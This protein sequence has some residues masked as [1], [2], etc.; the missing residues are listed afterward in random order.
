MLETTQLS[1]KQIGKKIG[2]DSKTIEKLIKPDAEHTFKI[3]LTSGKSFPAYRIQHNNKLGPYKGGIR[4]HPGVDKDEVQA[5][6]T[7]MSFKT[8]AVGLPLGGGKGGITVDPNQLDDI[9][10]EELSRKYAQYLTPHI[11]PN[12]DVPAP[13]V[14][15]DSRIIDWMVDE[16]EKQTGDR[17]KASFTG[18]SMKNG[19]SEGREAAT[20]RGGV[21]ALRQLLMLMKKADKKMTMAIQGF[22]NVGSFFA[23]VAQTEQPDWELVSASDSSGAV[24]SRS[25]LPAD[26]LAGFKSRGQHFAD[27]KSAGTKII[28][29]EDMLGL[30]VDVLVLAGL[31]DAVTAANMKNI[32]AKI[33]V[34]L[35]N[36]PISEPAYQ[37]LTKH[38]AIIVPD[39]VANSGGVIVSYLEWV[40][41]VKNQHWAEAKVNR[42][43]EEYMVKAVSDMYKISK[44]KQVPLKEAAFM[45][46]FSRLA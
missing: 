43:L 11:G 31:G 1:I 33:I 17:T 46:A 8:A 27:Y 42:Q 12:K 10:L 16:Y 39:I 22:G 28:S 41:N 23:I 14:N 44:N 34:E 32:K 9:E 15:T 19:G 40:Q 38:G 20:G 6:A 45:M 18:K 36:G 5:L 2:L 29:N 4:F 3:V 26:K 13:D 37:F 7:L 35:A 21:I 24:Y 30:D 25:K